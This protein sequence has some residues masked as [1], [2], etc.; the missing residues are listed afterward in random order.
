MYELRTTAP[1]GT[2]SR[3]PMTRN[4][5]RVEDETFT[6]TFE[7]SD[8]RRWDWL[9]EEWTTKRGTGWMRDM[10]APS[11]RT[12][13]WVQVSGYRTFSTLVAELEKHGEIPAAAW[14]V[15]ARRAMP[16]DE[17]R[18]CG[19]ATAAMTHMTGGRVFPVVYAN[20][21]LNF[22]PMEGG[23]YTGWRWLVEV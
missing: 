3:V 11:R 14:C 13:K 5:R 16:S 8:L 17:K 18:P 12:F 22:I 9:C 2:I 4:S 15:A 6:L 23:D 7:A 10:A 19:I 20:G 21:T 1:A